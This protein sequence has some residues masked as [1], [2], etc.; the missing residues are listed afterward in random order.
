VVI[1]YEMIHEARVIPLDGRPHAD[2]SVHQWLGDSRGRWDGDTLVVDVTNFSDK[3]SFRGSSAG[4]HLV[5]RFTR[6]DANTMNYEFTV[7]DSATWARPWDGRD[8]DAAGPGRHVRVCVPRGELRADRSAR[9]RTR[10]R[11]QRGGRGQEGFQLIVPTGRRWFGAASVAHVT[12]A[13]RKKAGPEA[14]G[15]GL[16]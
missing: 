7:S 3:T 5:E 2:P 12:V 14:L 4:L 9:R 8:A 16:L 1:L 10:R 13:V 6:L 15:A 11:A